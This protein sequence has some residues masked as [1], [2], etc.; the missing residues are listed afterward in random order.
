MGFWLRGH[1]QKQSADTVEPPMGHGWLEGWQCWGAWF[2]QDG[3][4]K[5]GTSAVTGLK[6][7]L[8][9]LSPVVLWQ[10]LQRWHW[11]RPRWSAAVQGGAVCT[12][13]GQH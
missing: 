4:T 13:L 6:P 8:V 2:M 9:L 12:W 1:P 5:V 3:D 10:V 7:S 11:A